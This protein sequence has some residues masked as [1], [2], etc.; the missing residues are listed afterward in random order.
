MNKIKTWKQGLEEQLKS[1]DFKDWKTK[2][3]K[4]FEKFQEIVGLKNLNQTLW[5]QKDVV[6]AYFECEVETVFV[7]ETNKEKNEMSFF[8]YPLKTSILVYCRIEII[9][10]NNIQLFL[11]M[12]EQT[13]Q[14]N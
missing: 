2:Y 6:L 13:L 7:K 12:Y 5:H 14:T 8:I 4:S 9:F 1:F 3:P 11:H 10:L